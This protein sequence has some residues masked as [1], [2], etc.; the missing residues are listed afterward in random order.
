VRSTPPPDE[1][2]IEELAS[3]DLPG[4]AAQVWRVAFDGLNPRNSAATAGQQGNAR[5]SVGLWGQSPGVP[6][7]TAKRATPLHVVHTLALADVDGNNNGGGSN[8]SVGGD[9]SSGGDGRSE[10]VVRSGSQGRGD[11][12]PASGVRFRYLKIVIEKPA[13]GWGVSL[14]QVD[15][16]PPD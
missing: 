3:S 11:N 13:A 10:G 15:L 6:L 16:L 14:W 1:G 7:K 4:S 8:S 5:L 9:S 2:V 12:A